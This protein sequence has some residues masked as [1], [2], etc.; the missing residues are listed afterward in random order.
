MS[1][2]HS[3]AMRAVLCWSFKTQ[4]VEK[5]LSAHPTRAS[6]SRLRA[7]PLKHE[8]V[9]SHAHYI[10]NAKHYSPSQGHDATKQPPAAQKNA[11]SLPWPLHIQT[12]DS[13]IPCN[14]LSEYLRCLAGVSQPII[15]FT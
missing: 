4:D 15:S 3:A 11:L 10:L 7:P 9:P 1:N 5:D 6:L 13:L 14:A 8:T 12:Q 2:S